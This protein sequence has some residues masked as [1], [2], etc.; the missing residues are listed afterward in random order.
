MREIEFRQAIFRGYILDS[1]VVCG[2]TGVGTGGV[3]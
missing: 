2:R 1:G 3:L